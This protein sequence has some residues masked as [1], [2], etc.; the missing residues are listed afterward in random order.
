MK[1]ALV[2]GCN[3][4]IG[5]KLVQYL[6]NKNIMVIGMDISEMPIV[7]NDNFKYHKIDFSSEYTDIANTPIDV[8]YNLCWIGVSTTDKNDISKQ[9]Q[10]IKLTKNILV[11]CKKLLVRKVIISGST[12]EFSRV[13]GKI[14]GYEDNSPSDTYA[15]IKTVVRKESFDYCK[16]NGI[17]LNWLLITSIYSEDRRDAN[18]IFSVIKAINNK[19]EYKT[20]KLEQ[21]WDYIH[22]DDLLQAMY[23]VGEKGK[24]NCIYPVGSGVAKTL[25]E[26]VDVIIRNMNGEQWIK[27]G[28]LPYKNTFIDNSIPDISK[29]K[30]LGYSPNHVFEKDI[31]EIIRII[32]SE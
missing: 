21:K 11:L 17:D 20:T 31:I 10:N 15:K 29:L 23:L 24:P 30:K 6:L 4:F 32:R 9:E 12:S 18:L 7:F 27:V 5:R 26:Y 13:I 8:A 16:E 22:V 14:T 28:M 2:L 25:K 3:G 19:E 1:T